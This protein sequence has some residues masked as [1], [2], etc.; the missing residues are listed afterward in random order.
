MPVSAPVTV[1]PVLTVAAAV[2]LLLQLPPAAASVSRVEEP[3]HIA[4][5]PEIVPALGSALTLK[6]AVVLAVPQL[7]VTVYNILV[8]PAV[9]PATLPPVLTVATAILLLLQVPPEVAS[10][11]RV[12]EPAHILSVPVMDPADGSGLTVTVAVSVV[13]PQLLVAA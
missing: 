5:A 12:A 4:E 1:P 7:L 13:V 9:M 8:L 6:V 10:A 3:L 2:L 11:R